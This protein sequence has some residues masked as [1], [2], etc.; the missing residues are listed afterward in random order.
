[1]HPRVE[2]YIYTTLLHC[3]VTTQCKPTIAIIALCGSVCVTAMCY[4]HDIHNIKVAFNKGCTQKH[5]NDHTYM[6]ASV[7]EL[8]AVHHLQAVALNMETVAATDDDAPVDNTT[9][10]AAES[11]STS[12]ETDISRAR[13]IMQC[14]QLVNSARMC[15]DSEALRCA[16]SYVQTADASLHAIAKQSLT[17]SNNFNVVRQMPANK[18]LDKQLRFSTKVKRRPLQQALQKPSAAAITALKEASMP[19][20]MFC[21]IVPYTEEVSMMDTTYG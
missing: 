9:S 21:V 14:H 1:M 17:V 5:V 16:L 8:N 13:L 15:D 10:D 3:P 7:E 19:A 2:F 18:K 11:S 12:R 20:D 4:R 6:N